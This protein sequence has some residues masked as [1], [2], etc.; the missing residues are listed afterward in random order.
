MPT[1]NKK[2]KKQMPTQNKKMKKQMPTH[3]NDL[4]HNTK[5]MKVKHFEDDSSIV[6]VSWCEEE[7]DSWYRKMGYKLS[8]YK[9]NEGMPYGIYYYE[10]KEDLGHIECQWFSTELK[11]DKEF[12][13]IIKLRC[14]KNENV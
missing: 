9:D 11:R 10:D 5:K 6:K 7:L 1:Q 14:E 8:V 4:L 3:E 2:M 12:D 13:K